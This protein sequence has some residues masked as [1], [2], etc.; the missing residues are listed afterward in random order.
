MAGE[1]VFKSAYVRAA[2]TAN[3]GSRLAQW[4]GKS[5][6]YYYV[7]RA[8]GHSQWE[9]PTEPAPSAPTPDPTPQQAIDPFH[10]PSTPQLHGSKEDGEVVENNDRS[11][12]NY[13]GA[14]RGL[15]GVKLP[16][17]PT[18]ANQSLLT[19]LTSY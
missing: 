1:L 9:I 7:Q 10:K 2:L 18:P 15:L 5:R 8:T 19:S 6:K 12:E 16:T 14:D 11:V 17:F 3:L 13:Q 4:E